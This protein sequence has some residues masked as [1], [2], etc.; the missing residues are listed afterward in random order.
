MAV[1]GFFRGEVAVRTLS[2][3]WGADG[4]PGAGVEGTLA[5]AAGVDA[6][7]ASVCGAGLAGGGLAGVDGGGGSAIGGAAVCAS[8]PAQHATSTTPGR[9]PRIRAFFI[10]NLPPGESA[11]E[12]SHLGPSLGMR[13][14]SRVLFA[15]TTN[16]LRPSPLTGRGLEQAFAASSGT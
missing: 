2:C 4:A 9:E 5:A 15:N 6:N 12:T 14:S 8:A 10:T 13:W 11:G 3:A 7:E 16:R 1:S